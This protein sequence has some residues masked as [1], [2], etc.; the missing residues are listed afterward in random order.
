[1]V[2][3]F[4]FNDAF[5]HGG[6]D[7]NG[8]A[9]T[10]IFL[11]QGGVTGDLTID[12][13]K[14][15]LQNDRHTR[16]EVDLEGFMKTDIDTCV[17]KC[18]ELRVTVEKKILSMTQS[19]SIQ[20]QAGSVPASGHRYPFSFNVLSW[21][22]RDEQ[23]R[24]HHRVM[25]EMQNNFLSIPPSLQHEITSTPQGVPKPRAGAR[26]TYKLTARLLRNQRTVEK[27]VQPILLLLSSGPAPP[28]CLADYKGE[29]R[30]CEKNALKGSFRQKLGEVS[31]NVQEPK[32]LVVRT[33]SP[34][35]MV[36]LPVK[37]RWEMPKESSPIEYPRIEAEV[38][39]QFR[40]S[41]F[42]SMLEQRGPPT[43]KQA[44]ASPATAF[45]RSSLNAR[46]M[47]VVWRDWRPTYDGEVNVVESEQSLWLTFPRAEI[48]TPTFWS[49]FLSRRY[50][51]RLQLKI[52]NP[53]SAKYDVEVPVQVCVEGATSA[54]PDS[55]YRESHD[56]LLEDIEGDELL[57]QYVR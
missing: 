22:R 5:R 24:P 36:E 16:I 57:P 8:R 11:V 17:E 9:Q 31:V 4:H 52:T 47:R 44:L 32:Q 45:V 18:S 38:K 49:P 56:M 25:S 2:L 42:V 19:I 12:G 35:S 29:Y 6:E 53:G 7:G 23:S 46:E 34:N 50:S 43:L 3:S 37:L 30:L 21:L 28:M 54:G 1:M 39:W 20:G 48:L 26:V 14:G 40:F 10:P 33:C 41:T 27:V 55:T 51:I 15:G 13:V